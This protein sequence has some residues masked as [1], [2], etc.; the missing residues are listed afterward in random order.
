MASSGV[1]VTSQDRSSSRRKAIADAAIRTIAKH[2]LAGV[3][4]RLVAKEAEVSLAATTY[5]YRTKADIVAD[6]SRELLLG[7]VASIEDFADRIEREP[8]ASMRDYAIRLAMNAAGRHHVQAIAWF[9]IML[10]AARQDELQELAVQ[11]FADMSRPWERICR[12]AGLERSDEATRATIDTMIGLTLAT[13]ALGIDEDRAAAVL[14]GDRPLHEAWAPRGEAARA[15]IASVPEAQTSRAQATRDRIL[16]AAIDLL[17]SDGPSGVTLRSVA[18]KAGIAAAA[19]TYHF[20]RLDLLLAAAHQRMFGQS[21]AR[22]RQN[23]SRIDYETLDAERLIDF[24]NTVLI[25]ETTEHGPTNVASYTLWMEATRRPELVPAIWA[26]LDDQCRAWV[27]LLDLIVHRGDM[28]DALVLNAQFIGKVIR[29][30]ATGSAT[31]DLARARGEFAREI[32]AVLEGRHWM[33]A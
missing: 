7:Y 12:A 31:A 17:A 11:A 24:T 23:A 6:A 28:L 16:T 25:R 9:E 15:E 33:R 22:Y 32:G 29:I 18:E 2:G 1:R 26:F 3:T 20:P 27:R 8:Q 19:P 4:H 10:A 13:S 30:V 14:R 21:K 5:Y